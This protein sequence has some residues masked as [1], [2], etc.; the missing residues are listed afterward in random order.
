MNDNGK[1]PQGWG[2]KRSLPENWGENNNLNFSENE[3]KPDFVQAVQEFGEFANKVT[4]SAVKIAGKTSDFLKSDETREKIETAKYIARSTAEGVGTV[5]ADGAV[6]TVDKARKIKTAAESAV[7]DFTEETKLKAVHAK[8]SKK[9]IDRSGNPKPYAEETI[10]I[11][12]TKGALSQ[13]DNNKN[14]YAD[15]MNGNIPNLLPKSYPPPSYVIPE[16]NLQVKTA[17]PSSAV[18]KSVIAVCAVAAVAGTILFAVNYSQ[19]TGNE[20]ITVKNNSDD[21]IYIL[22]SAVKKDEPA[23]ETIPEVVSTE[24]VTVSVTEAVSDKKSVYKDTGYTS[25][26]TGK[27][28]AAYYSM[29][30][31]DHDFAAPITCG[32]TDI[33]NLGYNQIIMPDSGKDNYR[34]YTFEDNKIK[35][36]SFGMLMSVSEISL[37]RVVNDADPSHN[38]IY[39]RCNYASKSMQGYFDPVTGDEVRINLSFDDDKAYWKII[40]IKDGKSSDAYTGSESVSS[41]YGSTPECFDAIMKSFR[42]IGFSINADSKYESIEMKSAADTLSVLQNTVSAPEPVQNIPEKNTSALSNSEL[43]KMYNAYLYHV[44]CGWFGGYLYDSDGDG[45]EELYLSCYEGYNIGTFKNGSAEYEYVSGA[46]AGDASRVK[47][48][49]SLLAEVG[50][51]AANYGYGM[52]RN[53]VKEGNMT[54]M[55]KTNGGTLNIRSGPSTGESIIAELPNG[56]IMNVKSVYDAKLNKTIYAEEMGRD[57]SDIWYYVRA[58]YNGNTYYGYVSAEYIDFY[59][60][61]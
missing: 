55:V 34:Y 4:N 36:C 20:N 13:P 31:A 19:K 52:N 40:L 17:P 1:V 12:L 53:F 43:G 54:G 7:S 37:Y 21:T 57:K 39:Y 15:T 14:D 10:S 38:Y 11:D 60:S 48:R 16:Q 3:N 32:L 35:V 2:E 25:S 41:V 30:S 18:K 61:H 33:N 56:F 8:E 58:D 24:E 9:T 59:V 51:K 6:K 42:D 49:E 27:L 46:G 23:A 22:T 47:S 28:Y 29:L 26:D 50:E 44:I 5:I 45:T